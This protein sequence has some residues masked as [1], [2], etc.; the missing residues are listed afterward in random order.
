M[1]QTAHRPAHVSPPRTRVSPDPNGV[2]EDLIIETPA[3]MWT[4]E[5]PRTSREP[6]SSQSVSS[7]TCWR[8]LETREAAERHYLPS[9]PMSLARPPPPSLT[10][11]VQGLDYQVV[12][13]SCDPLEPIR[14]AVTACRRCDRGQNLER[15]TKRL[16]EELKDLLPTV[17]DLEQREKLLKDK[18]ST[19]ES[20]LH[21][22][23]EESE[24]LNSEAAAQRE[25]DKLLKDENRSLTEEMVSLRALNQHSYETE[26][27]MD[28]RAEEAQLLIQNKDELIEKL[29]RRI[30][31]NQVLKESY[32]LLKEDLHKA[33]RDLKEQLSEEE[34]VLGDNQNQVSGC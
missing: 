30:T 34:Q 25:K 6:C 24:S 16:Q 29:H 8:A 12:S 13:V 19:T 9:P 10:G 27:E 32:S 18:Q 2:G 20:L 3:V 17:K 1:V 28:Q 22:I 31:Y 5:S 21:Q 14:T 7:S 26:D 33:V 15:V 4:C 11:R 23:Q